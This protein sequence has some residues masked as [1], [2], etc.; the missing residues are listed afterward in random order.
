MEEFVVAYNIDGIDSI[1]IMHGDE[2]ASLIGFQDCYDLEYC[3]VWKFNKQRMEM[4]PC[5]ICPAMEPPF[6]RLFVEVLA[7]W[8]E[9]YWY[10]W[11][12]H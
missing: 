10:E 3:H 4:I 9:E 11:Q 6:N 2:L 7:G 5:R 1:A 8:T 12:E